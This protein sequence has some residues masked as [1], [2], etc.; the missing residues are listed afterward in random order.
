MKLCDHCKWANW[1]RTA[2]GRLHPD[3]SGSCAKEWQPPPLPAAFY[4]HTISTE[5]PRPSG[6]YIKRGE[7]LNKHCPYW[8]Q[9]ERT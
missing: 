9:E 3:K 5:I 4:F 2:S 1:K 7:E 8:E 6:G